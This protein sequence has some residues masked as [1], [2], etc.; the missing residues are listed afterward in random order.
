MFG[1]VLILCAVIAMAK[2]ASLENRSAVLW[3]TITFLVCL[4]CAHTIPWPFLNIFIG[5]IASYLAMFLCNIL[6][7][8]EKPA[9][10]QR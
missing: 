2:I 7:T 8:R 3:G 1:W 6:F 4:A 9:S 10:I 5:L